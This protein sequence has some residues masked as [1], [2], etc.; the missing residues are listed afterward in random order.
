[1]T[2]VTEPDCGGIACVDRRE[3]LQTKSLE[4]LD[5]EELQT[6]VN[7]KRLEESLNRSETKTSVK[8]DTAISEEDLLD[9]L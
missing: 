1:M 2:P 5:E 6:I 3:I 7:V 9:N 4:L 8:N